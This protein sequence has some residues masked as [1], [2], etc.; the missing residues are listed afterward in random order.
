[1]SI[2]LIMHL[3]NK[4]FKQ[5]KN[6]LNYNLSYICSFVECTK[7]IEDFDNHIY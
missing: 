5:C 3:L 1:M 2:A 4:R 6:S 7:E